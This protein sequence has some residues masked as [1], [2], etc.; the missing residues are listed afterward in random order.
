[1]LLKN[2]CI[3]FGRA[4]DNKRGAQRLEMKHARHQSSMS[5]RHRGAGANLPTRK[6]TLR[7]VLVGR[8]AVTRFRQRYRLGPTKRR[9]GVGA[10]GRRRNVL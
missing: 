8:S 3:A 10:L 6:A 7:T 1:M 4:C 9:N 5:E 2:R